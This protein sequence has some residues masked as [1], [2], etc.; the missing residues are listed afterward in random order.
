MSAATPPAGPRTAPP[1]DVEW[2][3]HHRWAV[4]PVGTRR[5][6][7][8]QQEAQ[9]IHRERTGEG[10]A[11]SPSREDYVAAYAVI[12]ADYAPAYV[13]AARDTV[14]PGCGRP[15]AGERGLALHA[16]SRFVAAGCRGV[17]R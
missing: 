5:Q 17:T 1:T 10:A 2:A 3:S 13:P 14:C 6:L 4:P 12:P 15:F 11:S 7:W 9:A 8:V 16:S